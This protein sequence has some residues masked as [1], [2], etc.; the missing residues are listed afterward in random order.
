MGGR[1]SGRTT[2]KHLHTGCFCS[3]WALI[4][5]NITFEETRGLA[6][7]DPP[8]NIRDTKTNGDL[9]QKPPM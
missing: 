5:L 3:T 6:S 9:N 4:K 1:G 8:R 7:C 2:N